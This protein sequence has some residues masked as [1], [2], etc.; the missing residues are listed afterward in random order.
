MYLHINKSKK[1]N[2][3]CLFSFSSKILISQGETSYSFFSYDIW[4]HNI[5]PI[6]ERAI[7]LPVTTY[8]STHNFPLQNSKKS[9]TSFH[10]SIKR[11]Y[12][13]YSV[14]NGIE[15]AMYLNTVWKQSQQLLRIFITPISA[16]RNTEYLRELL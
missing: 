5:F 10:P 6:R 2:P 16:H 4:V 13:T 8:K 3:L 11:Q 12:C 14:E 9:E 7:I 15:A 1:H